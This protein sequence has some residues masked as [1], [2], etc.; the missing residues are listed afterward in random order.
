MSLARA[1]NEPRME[2]HD[3]EGE[4]GMDF[5]LNTVTDERALVTWAGVGVTTVIAVG[6]GILLCD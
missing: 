6:V 1:R 4:I 3:N 2:R 5:A